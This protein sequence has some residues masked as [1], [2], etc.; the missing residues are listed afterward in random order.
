MRL[1]S[2]RSRRRALTVVAAVSLTCG[3]ALAPQAALADD[4]VSQETIEQ[5]GS[6]ASE[7]DEQDVVTTV[8][9]T[10]EV[11]PSESAPADETP[12]DQTPAVEQTPAVDDGTTTDGVADGS[13]TDATPGEQPPASG[14]ELND[15]GNAPSENPTT[16]VVD[17]P[18]EG[19]ADDAATSGDDAAVVEEETAAP[20]E[21][22]PKAEE[23]TTAQPAAAQAAP[24]KKA[25]ASSASAKLTAQAPVVHQ[26]VKE[27]TYVIESG[28]LA[29]DNLGLAKLVLDAR[30]VKNGAEVITWSYNGKNNQ[31]WIV[32]RDGES[33]WYT[34]ASYANS[35]LVLTATNNKGKL[36][37]TNYV[38]GLASQLWAFVLSGKGYGTG[39][40]LVPKGVQ[41]TAYD[42]T[43]VSNMPNKALDVR[44]GKPVNG[45][46]VITYTKS[47][48]VKPN[49]SVYLVNP[50]PIVSA[51]LKNMEGKYRFFVPGTK[52]VLEVRRAST[53]NRA[54]IWTWESNGKSHQDVYLQDEGNGFYSAWI[55]GT[56]KVLDVQGSSILYGTNVIQWAYS[57]KANQQ[58]AVR[59]NAD[60]TYSLINR[61]TG[62]VLGGASEKNGKYGNGT[63]LVGAQDNGRA[64]NAFSLKRS[65]LVSAGIYK[66]IKTSNGRALDVSRASTLSGANIAFYSDNGKLNQRFELVSAGETDLW[67]IRTAS[68]GGWVTLNSNNKI[69]Q[70]GNHATAKSAANTWHI[71]W[72]NG[73]YQFRNSAHNR[74]IGTI[75]TKF[76]V[77]KA[78]I[79]FNGMFELDSKA[80][81]VVLDN[82]GSSKASGKRYVV[83]RSN[84]GMNQRFRIE[85]AGNGFKITNIASGMALTGDNQYVIQKKYSG[86]SNQIWTFGIA[87]G[88]AVRIINS[89]TGRALDINGSGSVSKS[90]ST[91][92]RANPVDGDREA[93]Q[94]WKIKAADGFFTSGGTRY[95]MRAN[96]TKIAV[97]NAC[98]AAYKS[99]QNKYSSSKYI[100]VIDN[101][102]YRTF[103][104]TGSKGNWTPYADWAATVGT[105]NGGDDTFGETF[106]GTSKVRKKGYMMGQCPYEFYW[107]EFY[108]N[109]AAR[110]SDGE[111]QRFH[112]ILYW[113]ASPKSSVYDGTLGAAASHGCVRLA[114]DN[115]K[116]VYKNIPIGTTVWSY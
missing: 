45:S 73:E 50:S 30:A 44:G 76:K 116:W 51:G 57:G 29:K 108:I 14:E 110:N 99:V 105:A 38:S 33:D 92:V 28:I 56:K 66:L 109:S 62:L 16:E 80:A 11:V 3:L 91:A 69:V 79:S 4:E 114:T 106:R 13:T 96:G 21:V 74:Y 2:E 18:V 94:G 85:K 86:A 47:D 77:T 71:L 93:R 24:A 98:Y 43:I 15:E 12:V 70:Q 115:A 26:I 61:A 102:H 90:S 6:I 104:F 59:K 53:E 58:W 39:Y 64:N 46:D 41:K 87:D 78:P 5:E 75:D 40:Q 20:E 37:L 101:S 36:Y 52:V 111:G 35:K 7:N 103:V 97:S 65:P 31:K 107:T 48:T 27:G 8:P 55:M 83:Y 32:L 63:N 113:G 82:P 1:L 100:M 34:I 72:R 10:D 67:R 19:V 95:Y 22:A 89:S 84:N 112:S 60:G 68:S 42:K 23:S 25:T 88:G 54:N 9:S 17:Q 49:Q 81:S